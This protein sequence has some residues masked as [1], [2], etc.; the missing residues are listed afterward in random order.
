M[1]R[2]ICI[3]PN[4]VR[5]SRRMQERARNRALRVCW[6][7]ESWQGIQE[8]CI[9]ILK[10]C[11]FYMHISLNPWALSNEKAYSKTPY[12]F[13]F[14]LFFSFSL[15]RSSPFAAVR[16]I[17]HFT[18]VLAS[19]CTNNKVSTKVLFG[20]VI[21]DLMYGSLSSWKFTCDSRNMF[22]YNF[23]PPGRKKWIQMKRN[24][25]H[26]ER[27]EVGNEWILL[28][29]IA[30]CFCHCYLPLQCARLCVHTIWYMWSVCIRVLGLEVSRRRRRRRHRCRFAKDFV[31]FFHKPSKY[32][33]S[34]LWNEFWC[35]NPM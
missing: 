33:H 34:V 12:H 21:L 14:L 29:V 10:L 26:I 23:K 16:F 4:A 6:V 20:C 13:F 30:L 3:V 32:C 35:D 19:T 22:A 28:P 17:V 2:F 15:P 27:E 18:S 1:L 7:S 8:A 5:C 31:H 24:P 11:I 9:I 25:T